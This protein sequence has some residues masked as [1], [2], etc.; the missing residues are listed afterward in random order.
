MQQRWVIL[1]LLAGALLSCNNTPAPISTSASNPVDEKSGYAFEMKRLSKTAGDCHTENANCMEIELR[2]P[3]LTG[4]DATVCQRINESIL[5]QLL[6]SFELADEEEG[7]SSLESALQAVLD[8]FT[9]YV[10]E[11]E[12][13][14]G[15]RWYHRIEGSGSFYKDIAVVDLPLSTYYGGTHPNFVQSFSNFHLKTGTELTLPDLV[16]DTSSF[17]RLAEKAFFETRLDEEGSLQKTDFFWDKPFYLPANFALTEKGIQ[18]FYNPYEAAPYSLGPT[19]FVL[20]W[21]QLKSVIALP[22]N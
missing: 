21:N 7:P 16:K 20:P 3:L 18:L 4:G 10:T 6:A 2:Y 19:D 15:H 22:A 13:G 9:E 17:N 11:E 14:G 12:Q 5:E 8:D 1:S